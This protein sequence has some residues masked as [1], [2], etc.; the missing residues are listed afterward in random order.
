MLDSLEVDWLTT[1]TKQYERDCDIAL[2]EFNGMFVL[3]YVNPTSHGYIPPMIEFNSD[4]DLTAFLLR[5][6]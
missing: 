6:S 3:G 5:W 4:A 1:T 2:A